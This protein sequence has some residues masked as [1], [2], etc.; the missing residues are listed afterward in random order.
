MKTKLKRGRPGEFLLKLLCQCAVTELKNV[1]D[2]QS[3]W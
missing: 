3:D 2:V 1:A